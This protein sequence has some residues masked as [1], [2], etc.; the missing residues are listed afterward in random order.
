MKW[1]RARPKK[2]G[3][4]WMKCEGRS[5]KIVEV[6]DT[7]TDEPMVAYCGSDMDQPIKELKGALWYGPLEPPEEK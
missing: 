3:Y 4:Y 7:Q 6:W 2:N 1:F 5:I